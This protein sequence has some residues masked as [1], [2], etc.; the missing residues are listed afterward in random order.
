[1]VDFFGLSPEL[2]LNRYFVWQ[3]VT[4]MFVH[5]GLFHLVLNMI[6]LAMFGSPLEEL[7]GTKQFLIFCFFTGIGAGLCALLAGIFTMKITVG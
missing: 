4:Y 2:V 6:Y 5:I 7:W 1:M 3:I